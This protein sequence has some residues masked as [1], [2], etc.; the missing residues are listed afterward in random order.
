MAICLGWWWMLLF[1]FSS[2]HDVFP[3]NFCDRHVINTTRKIIIITSVLF[4]F[5][6]IPPSIQE[7]M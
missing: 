4:L 2:Y 7:N 6:V 3:Q 1:L 5:K